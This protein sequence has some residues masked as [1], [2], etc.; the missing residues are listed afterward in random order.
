[1]K[2]IRRKHPDH[3]VDSCKRSSV[4]RMAAGSR[5]PRRQA[6]SVVG[7]GVCSVV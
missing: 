4:N 6:T 1:M 3:L 7:Q 2:I 5:L